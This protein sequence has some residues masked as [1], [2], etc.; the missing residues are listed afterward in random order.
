LIHVNR[1]GGFPYHHSRRIGE[2]AMTDFC[3]SWPQ[4]TRVL[5]QAAQMDRMM[6]ALGVSPARAARIDRGTAF[7]EAR[8]RCIAC[9]AD[10]SCR[11]WLAELE[12]RKAP[13]PPAFCANA[14]FFRIAREPADC[15]QAE[16]NDGR[17]G[18]KQAVATGVEQPAFCKR[19]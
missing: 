11:A 19:T 10:Q 14:E 12:G 9:T 17:I 15:Q 2:N 16:E 3:Y 18:T 13:A 7:Y 1:A 4:L 5:T 8:T 6:D